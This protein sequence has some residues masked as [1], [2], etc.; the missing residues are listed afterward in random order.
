[1]NRHARARCGPVTLPWSRCYIARHEYLALQEEA[2]EKKRV[3]EALRR[4]EK[5]ANQ[6]GKKGKKPPPKKEAPK[7]KVQPQRSLVGKDGQPTG[8]LGRIYM[9]APKDKN[10]A[11]L[12]SQRLPVG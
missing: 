1:M 12:P 11:M 8:E 7:K 6:K 3:A 2:R 9:A 4:K 10:L 5:E